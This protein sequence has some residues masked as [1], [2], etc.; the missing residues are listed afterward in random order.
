MWLFETMW[1]AMWNLWYIIILLVNFALNLWFQLRPKQCTHW[2]KMKQGLRVKIIFMRYEWIGFIGKQVVYTKI[3]IRN[4]NYL[5]VLN[6]IKVLHSILEFLWP[7]TF[8]LT[9]GLFHFKKKK[10]LDSWESCVGIS[11]CLQILWASEIL[12]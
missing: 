12:S 8:D 10:W 5:K 7:S 2:F 6:S 9:K 4:K 11:R 3:L 1:D